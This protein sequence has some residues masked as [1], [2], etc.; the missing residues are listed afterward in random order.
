M[1]HLVTSTFIA[2]ITASLPALAD[3]TRL[4]TSMTQQQLESMLTEEGYSM[5]TPGQFS[6]EI[7][8]ARK[9][10]PSAHAVGAYVRHADV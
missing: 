3:D 10:H 2:F 4:V 9:D 5:E 6:A 7:N 1:R 8:S